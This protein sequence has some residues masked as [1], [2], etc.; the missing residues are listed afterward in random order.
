MEVSLEVF[1]FKLVRITNN[2]N[3]TVIGVSILMLES[4]IVEEGI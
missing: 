3:L 2:E 4:T 1:V